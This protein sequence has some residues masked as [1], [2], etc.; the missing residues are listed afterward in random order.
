MV[1]LSHSILTIRATTLMPLLKR[2]RSRYN[3]SR[4]PGLDLRRPRLSLPM[5]SAELL[6]SH[7]C[8]PLP[9]LSHSQPN[10]HQTSPL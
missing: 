10:S 1:S 5:D 8:F 9:W 3:K 7:R 2:Q 4:I 6:R